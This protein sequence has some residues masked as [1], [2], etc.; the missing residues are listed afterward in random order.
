[1]KM[2][3][4]G[5]IH[6][7]RLVKSAVANNPK[8]KPKYEDIIARP[9]NVFDTDDFGIDEKEAAALIA[10]RTAKRQTREVPVEAEEPVPEPL[11]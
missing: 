3:A 10:S 7:R 5:T 2:I 11:A 8:S 9:G 4:I 1:M 6:G